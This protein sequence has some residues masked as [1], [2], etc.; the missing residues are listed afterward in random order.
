MTV[1]SFSILHYTQNSSDNL[2]SY[3]ERNI[4]AQDVVYWRRRENR[5]YYTEYRWV[6]KF[7]P[8]VS[9]LWNENS[10]YNLYMLNFNDL[11]VLIIK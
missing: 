11:V 9:L 3:L 5:Q 4:I 7:G 2:P 10:A 1:H 8:P 6:Q